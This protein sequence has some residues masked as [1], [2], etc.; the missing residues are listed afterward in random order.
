MD[1]PKNWEELKKWL[2]IQDDSSNTQNKNKLDKFELV[3]DAIWKCEEDWFTDN[4]LLDLLKGIKECEICVTANNVY[5]ILTLFKKKNPNLKFNNISKYAWELIKDNSFTNYEGK[6]ASWHGF[7][8]LLELLN[9]N[10][11]LDDVL[12]KIRSFTILQ[13]T[14]LLIIW[15]KKNTKK[16][17]DA[18]V[19]LARVKDVSDEPSERAVHMALLLEQLN[20]ICK[21]SELDDSKNISGWILSKLHEYQPVNDMCSLAKQLKHCLTADHATTILEKTSSDSAE[22][23]YELIEQ[24]PL[25]KSHCKLI[26]K[27]LSESKAGALLKLVDKLVEIGFKFGRD[28]YEKVLGYLVMVK[29]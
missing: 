2:N 29:L 1:K 13:M 28:N 20:K 23:I 6:N 12:K 3:Y 15:N 21:L 26:F 9:D 7:C 18:A 22:C 24:L 25:G 8:N 17:E 4:N 16:K 19:I 27:K 11:V 14:N 5:R 10:L